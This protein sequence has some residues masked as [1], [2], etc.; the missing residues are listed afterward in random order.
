[1]ILMLKVYQSCLILPIQWHSFNSVKY[2]TIGTEFS[3]SSMRD[4][5]PFT[6]EYVSE[7][8][9]IGERELKLPRDIDCGDAQSRNASRPNSKLFRFKQCHRQIRRL[10]KIHAVQSTDLAVRRLLDPPEINVEEL[11]DGDLPPPDPR[12]GY[13]W[14]TQGSGKSLTMA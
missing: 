11:Q 12:G 14:H 6:S 5:H 9:T 1:M 8:F 3:V 10:F 7:L 2:G 13:V 4:P